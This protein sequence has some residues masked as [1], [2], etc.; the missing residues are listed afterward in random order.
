MCTSAGTPLAVTLKCC[1]LGVVTEQLKFTVPFG[2]PVWVVWVPVN[3]QLND[4]FATSL[5]ATVSVTVNPLTLTWILFISTGP[6]CLGILKTGFRCRKCDHSRAA[7]GH[8]PAKRCRNSAWVQY[9]LRVSAIANLCAVC[10][11]LRVYARQPI[12]AHVRRKRL[13]GSRKS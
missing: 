3:E 7:A 5:D 6:G 11:Q 4:P 9:S 1:P 2:V 13:V 8:R 12:E 10:A